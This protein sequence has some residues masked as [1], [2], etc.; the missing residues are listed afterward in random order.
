MRF[1]HRTGEFDLTRR[2]LIF[3]IV[4]VTPDSFSD[5]GKF[6]SPDSAIARALE[7][8][9]HGADV[10]D[11]GGESTR[12]GAEPVTAEEELRRILPVIKG[13]RRQTATPISVD[14]YKAK[15]A[16]VAIEAGA[17]IVNDISSFRLDDSMPEV[18]RRS[19]VGLVL[20]HMLGTPRTMQANP[21]Y[22]DVVGEV[23][24]FLEERVRC[25]ISSGIEPERIMI[26]PGIGFG[27]T[28]EHNLQL[29]RGLSELRSLGRPLLVG[30]SRK[31]FIAKTVGDDLDSRDWGTAATV[32]Y[33]IAQGANAIRVHNVQL[34][35]HVARMT[36][37]ILR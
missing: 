36:D 28:V 27:K 33:C 34:C 21:H 3:G 1:R 2:T 13:V 6:L 22:G 37:A 31:S 32:A 12:P 10:L 29:L 15:V 8:V 25:A 9:T 26:D 35:Q 4:N 24:S 7:L 17:S 16:N 19:R 18:V 30:A 20:M 14:T 23:R 11:I 5:G